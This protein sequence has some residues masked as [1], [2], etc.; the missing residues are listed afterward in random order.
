MGKDSRLAL[1]GFQAV[2]LAPTHQEAQGAVAVEVEPP[3]RLVAPFLVAHTACH[4]VVVWGPCVAFLFP[5]FGF[6]CPEKELL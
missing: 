1:S 2:A 3:L 4:A 6:W 5:A